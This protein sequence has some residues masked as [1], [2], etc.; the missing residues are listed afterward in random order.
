MD[1][2]LKIRHIGRVSELI[3][4]FI[5]MS[6]SINRGAFMLLQNRFENFKR[7]PETKKISREEF[8]RELQNNVELEDAYLDV[9]ST[10][11]EFYLCQIKHEQLNYNYCIMCLN[12]KMVLL[13]YRE[14]LLIIDIEE[15]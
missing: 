11:A 13:Y 4:P 2:H 8:E 10:K 5:P 7:W 12:K 9:F 3:E 14:I 6:E 1:K 15:I